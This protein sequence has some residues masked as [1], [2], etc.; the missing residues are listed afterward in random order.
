M[1]LKFMKLSIWVV[2]ALCLAGNLLANPVVP[3]QGIPEG[4]MASLSS[5]Q[6]NEREKAYAQLREWAGKN[7]KSAPERLHQVWKASAEPE[8]KTRCYRLMKELVLQRQFGL[9][10]GFIG[11][12]MKNVFLPGNEDGPARPGA[13]ISMI[14]ADS[15]A[16]KVE[17]RLGDVITQVDDLDFGKAFRAGPVIPGQGIGE[18]KLATSQLITYIKS[19]QPGDE[20]T[21][22][23]MR[24]A[25]LIE[26][27]VVLMKHPDSKQRDIQR[28]AEFD[29]FFKG[30]LEKMAG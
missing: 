14:I 21:L 29:Q 7:P 22:Q 2:L 9:G 23:I 28:K 11:I 30:W 16:A 4:V 18:D 15:P 5:D 17:L 1:Q 25:K 13:S 12:Q 27:K 20:V 8:A 10:W 19:K 26:V 3:E 6:H 24:G